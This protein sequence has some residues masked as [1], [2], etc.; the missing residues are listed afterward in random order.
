MTDEAYIRRTLALAA[1]A[2]GMTSPNPMVGALLIKNGKVISE[3]YH[4]KAGAPH[5]E[6]IAID[7]AEQ[8]AKGSSLYVS[9][10]PCCHKDKR[11]PPCTQKIISSGIR[12]VIVSMKDPNPKVAGKGVEELQKAGIQVITGI[13]E[14]K[15][16]ELNEAY[17]KH[18]TSGLPFVIMKVA[19]T[20]DGK[21][22]TPE[23]ESKW[24]TGGKAR[25]AVHRLR[26]SVD[27]IMTGIGTVKADD[28]QLTCRTGRLKDPL[29]IVID[30][31]L[32]TKTDAR[33][34]SCP[35]ET[36]IVTRR[37]DAGLNRS[38]GW[39]KRRELLEGKGARIIEYE[40]ERL[41]PAWLMKELGRLGI[42]SVLVEGGSSL[43]SSCLESGIVDK[44]MFFIAPKIIGGRESFTSVGGK[45]FRRLDEAFMLRD[46]KIRRF[47]EDFLIEGYIRK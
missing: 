14:E 8:R 16:R 24:I 34:L 2:R 13:L 1:R 40:G 37:A 33:V 25:I 38:P 35:P 23:G 39:K 11:T 31:L 42:V 26:G 22:A 29:R 20:L 46:T 15:A 4:K 6:V 17:I 9:L 3:G 32:E 43:N 5:A 30:P 7:K 36:I 18:V 27:A 47:G 21:I 12:K 41:D 44:V 28:P 19:M 10:E 45:T